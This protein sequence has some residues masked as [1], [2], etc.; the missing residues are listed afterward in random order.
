[1]AELDYNSIPESTRQS[2]LAA[3]YRMAEEMFQDPEIVK[4]YEIWLENRMKREK[5]SSKKFN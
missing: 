3:T 4:E 1:M 2:L 5:S